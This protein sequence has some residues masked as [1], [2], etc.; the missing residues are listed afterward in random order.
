MHTQVFQRAWR[1]A[2]RF[3]FISL[4]FCHAALIFTPGVASSQ[5]LGTPG[6]AQSDSYMINQTF[7]RQSF[8]KDI[9]IWVVT[10]EFAETFGMRPEMID[11]ELK[12]VE[13]VAFRIED[14]GSPLCGMGG[15]AESCQ[16]P[17]R[18]ML[19]IY[20]DERKHPLPWVT[21][22]KA[23]WHWRYNSSVALRTSTE[24]DGIVSLPD[25]RF[26]PNR[27]FKGNSS[28]HPFWDKNSGKEAVYFDISYLGGDWAN[29]SD[30]LGYKR[31]VIAGL[32]LV[33]FSQW[34]MS[35]NAAKRQLVYR[36]E[37]REEIMSP[38]IERFHEFI[39]PGR[40]VDQLRSAL[41]AHTEE[42]LKF[43]RGVVER[44]SSNQSK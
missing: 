8:F 16:K 22:Q 15:K 41:K 36:L 32:T 19:E 29:A 23:D 7:D 30:V 28:L 12:G 10:K 9:N 34:C 20:V 25:P 6:N 26:I 43:L 21:D 4:A 3:K 18:C 37:V 31:G 38:T 14:G 2:K 33:S 24:K 1:I 27:V 44:A 13:A 17:S 40:F 35:P 42:Q 39:V 11:P 5:L